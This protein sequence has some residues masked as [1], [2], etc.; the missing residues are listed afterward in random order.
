MRRVARICAMPKAA[1]RWRV[2]CRAAF[3]IG[4][5]NSNGCPANY[6]PLETEAACKSLAAIASGTYKTRSDYKYY[7]A[8]CFWHT[9]S[10]EFY[11]NTHGSGASNSFA[12]PLCA[13]A[14]A[15][16]APPPESVGKLCV[17]ASSYGTRV[18]SAQAVLGYSVLR[19]YSG[20]QRSG[21]TPWYSVVRRYSGVQYSGGARIPSNRARLLRKGREHKS[22][23]GPAA[24]LPTFSS[25][26]TA[27][28]VA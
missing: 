25:S 28:F 18:L 23:A 3:E 19:Q 2:E 14:P 20:T 27:A 9:V 1:A 13:G 26:G 8:R 10:R 4:G 22:T 17:P 15:R 6:S 11:W 24:S 7:P 12:Q 21:G 5:T 16:P